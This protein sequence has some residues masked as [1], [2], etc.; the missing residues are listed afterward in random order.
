MV[1]STRIVPLN[2]SIPVSFRKSVFGRIPA[3]MMSS[4]Q[5]SVPAEVFTPV[6]LSVPSTCCA[7]VPVRTRI[8]ALI[9]CFFAYAAISGSRMFGRIWGA[10]SMTVTLIPFA[11]RFSAASRPINPAP[12]TTAFFTLFASAY[13]RIPSASSGVRI[14]NT[15]GSSFPSIGSSAGEAPTAITSLS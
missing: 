11:C 13:V 3:A 8:P 7:L 9:R 14:L 15:P 12:I 2:I 1:L 5:G 6:T 4:S 10:K